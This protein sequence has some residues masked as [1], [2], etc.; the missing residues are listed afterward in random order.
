M[1]KK[2]FDVLVLGG[3]H[4]GLEAVN[5][6]AQHNLKTAIITMKNVGVVSAP[7]NP[8]IGGVGKGQVVR[9][10]DALGGVMGQLADMAGIQYRTLNEPKG[11]SVQSTRVQID[12]NLY[13]EFGQKLLDSW[14]NVTQFKLQA[15]KIER[16]EDLFYNLTLEDNTILAAKAC[17]I[18][19]GTFLGGVTHVG[20][21]SEKGGRREKNPSAG[22]KMLLNLNNDEMNHRLMSTS[23]RFKTGTPPRIEYS[24]IDFSQLEVQPSDG[25]TQNFHLGNSFYERK[26]PQVS[27]Y[28]TRTNKNTFDVIQENLSR[29]PLFNGQITSRGPRY[30]P[31]I[32]DKIHRYPDRFEHH[33]FL[34]PETLDCTT[35]YPNGISTSL[36]LDV[37]EKI[38]HSIKGL[39]KAHI[40]ISG[41]AV[42]YD[43]VDTTLLDAT[44][45]LKGVP[46]LFF[47]GQ[48]IGT[49]GYEEAA[50]LGL[51]AGINAARFI[52]NKSPWILNRL[53]SYIGV[54]VDDLIN[55][56]RDEPYRLFTA[57]CENRLKLRED[58][59]FVRMAP[60]RKELQL[61]TFLD[62]LLERILHDYHTLQNMAQSGK[63]EGLLLK[64]YLKMYPKTVVEK[65]EKVLKDNLIE[66]NPQAI[67]TC[68][69]DYIY[70]GVAQKSLLMQ[71]KVHRVDSKLLN[72]QS[73]INSPN[74]SFEC[75]ERIKIARP[76]N[77]RQLKEIPG[78]RAATILS[79]LTQIG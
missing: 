26:M 25:K 9:E 4:S 59:A 40:A 37:Q 27:C 29:S 67:R 62:T 30:C 23:K 35:V 41:Y 50:G 79:V 57:R 22:L 47:A 10:I 5:M 77:F 11:Y 39:E 61:H 18:T 71:E 6:C 70:E 68:A 48:L 44:L 3:G 16:G 60:Y 66:L 56:H 51:V 58:N 17:V 64:D 12:K 36:P 32:E 45:N 8:A 34:E 52:L 13:S 69:I 28:L 7:C 1:E 76:V 74:I 31:S 20:A 14:K 75:K 65:M 43:V 24:S 19:A 2:I 55:Q 38:V 54:M 72:Y 53:D 15:M 78:I 46:G 42:E 63:V 73:L 49:S 21:N 33:L